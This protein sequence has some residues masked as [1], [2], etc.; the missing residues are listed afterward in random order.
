MEKKNSLVSMPVEILGQILGQFALKPHEAGYPVLHEFKRNK[1][2]LLQLCLSCRKLS[3]VATQLLYRVVIFPKDS[4]RPDTDSL[5]LFLRTLAENPSLGANINHI[6]CLVNLKEAS[7]GDDS[8]LICESWRKISPGIGLNIAAD[9]PVYGVFAFTGLDYV[10]PYPHAIGAI[11]DGSHMPS[12]LGERIYATILCLLPSVESV[13]FQMPHHS[14]EPHKLEEVQYTVMS[15]II[16]EALQDCKLGPYML[17]KLHT[18]KIQPDMAMAWHA[19]RE[20]GIRYDACVGLL[21][22]PNLRVIEA[23]QESGGWEVLPQC[24]TDVSVYGYL[25]P[26]TMGII[27]NL[28]CLERLTVQPAPVSMREANR[29]DDIFNTALAKCALTLRYLDFQTMGNIT[30]WNYLGP[31]LRLHCLAKFAVLE[32]LSIEIFSLSPSS[33]DLPNLE[34]ADML[35]HSLR[36]LD[37]SERWLPRDPLLDNFGSNML[38]PYRKN[39]YAMLGRFAHACSVGG[40][41]IQTFEF[42]RHSDLTEVRGTPESKE[43]DRLRRTFAEAGVRLELSMF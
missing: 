41:T 10:L 36:T 31:E 17:Q 13:I 42:Q 11:A 38:N 29:N 14:A 30:L 34:L 16:G 27:C 25:Q 39:L 28:P 12:D 33:K 21:R 24:L 40:S 4:S 5:V 20:Y 15:D 8:R 2:T 9:F 32:H 6:A 1:A 19:E 18:V 23:F 3:A 37:L 22:A 35:P 7:N 43:F 26:H